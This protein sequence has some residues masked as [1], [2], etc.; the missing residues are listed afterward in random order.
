MYDHRTNYYLI[1]N[2]TIHQIKTG[3]IFK[4]NVILYFFYIVFR[5]G[6]LLKEVVKRY[7]SNFGI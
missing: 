5:I 3:F 6:K 1:I 2:L 7:F 4:S